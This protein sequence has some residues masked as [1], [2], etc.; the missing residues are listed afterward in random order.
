[1]RLLWC[2]VPPPLV[3]VFVAPSLMQLLVGAA[4]DYAPALGICGIVAGVL[5]LCLILYGW[6]TPDMIVE[7]LPRRLERRGVPRYIP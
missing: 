3:Y 2:L 5:T 6:C 4:A 1:M 7:R